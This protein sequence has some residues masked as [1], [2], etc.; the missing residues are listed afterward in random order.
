MY[1]LYDFDPLPAGF[2]WTHTPF[3]INTTPNPHT[4]CGDLTYEATFMGTA[5]DTNTSPVSYDTATRSYAIYSEDFGLIG[6]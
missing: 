4:L 5:L 6:S 3:T 1:D 2:I